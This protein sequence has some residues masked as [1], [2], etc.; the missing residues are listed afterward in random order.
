[1]LSTARRV[2]HGA[3]RV[4]SR[5]T[6]SLV[7]SRAGHVGILV[8]NV[9]N[10]AVLEVQRLDLISVPSGERLGATLI[11]EQLDEFGLDGE[12]LGEN[13]L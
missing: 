3:E 10:V 7:F 8:S 1:M 13:S 5:A 9:Q 4:D 12:P 11:G 6:R 2:D